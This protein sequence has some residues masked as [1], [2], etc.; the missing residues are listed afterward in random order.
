[1]QKQLVLPAVMALAVLAAPAEPQG[2]AGAQEVERRQY[3][4]LKITY[5][6]PGG[7]A[8]E[9]GLEPGDVLLK[10]DGT[11]LNNPA[12]LRHALQGADE[13]ELLILNCRTGRYE[14]LV[15]YPRYGKIGAD[16]VGVQL[17]RR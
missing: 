14:S 2:P 4:G 7:P 15:V 6:R 10:A 9:A 16:V 12:D 17:R 11:P 13:V 1:M 3:D 8:Y 5:V